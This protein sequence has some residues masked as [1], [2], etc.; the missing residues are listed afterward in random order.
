[1]AAQAKMLSSWIQVANPGRS[2][3]DLLNLT[4]GGTIM[5][6]QEAVQA[7]GNRLMGI[8]VKVMDSDTADD[9]LLLTDTSFEI[10]VADTSPR[11]FHLSVLVPASKLNN[12]E[13]FYESRAEIYC[14]V[15]ARAGTVQTNA[16]NTSTVSVA[17][18]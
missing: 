1:M 8:T 10:R 6:N 7:V 17:I 2:T 4:I 3:R 18:D 9:D 16:A 15:S 12:C 5:L 11:A 14:K 13:P